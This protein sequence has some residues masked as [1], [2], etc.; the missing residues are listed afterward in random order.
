MTTAALRPRLS[1]TER[2]AFAR[3]GFLLKPG[4]LDVERLIRPLQRELG[5]LIAHSAR[6]CGTSYT[7]P[8]DP[9]DF[10]AGYLEL[11]ARFPAVHKLVYDNAKNLTSFQ[12]LIVCDELHALFC[13][14]R[15][16]GFAGT[17]PSWNGIRID[18]PGDQLHSS[19]WHQEFQYQ[20]RSLDG[21]VLWTPLVPVTEAM[22]PVILAAGSHV[23][24]V[25]PLEDRTGTGESDMDR[26][27]Y[28]A[29][30]CPNEEALIGRYPHVAPLS[31]P[32]DLFA[33]DFLTLH[34]SGRNVSNRARFT[35]QLRYFNFEDAYGTSIGWTGGLKH[36]ASLAEANAKLELARPFQVKA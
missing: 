16:T 31:K 15:S 32:G 21:L 30:R 20:F 35:V 7:A 25:I 11:V 13:E 29:L 33:I 12:R 10:D 34:A 4:Y 17:A 24:G 27:E 9:A 5:L 6:S 18:S 1:D 26:G 36:G 3:D 22:G 14:L 19:P 28:A 23:E 2:A 8:K